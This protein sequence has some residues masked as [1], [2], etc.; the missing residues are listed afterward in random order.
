MVTDIEECME[1]LAENLS[2]NLP[3]GSF[4]SH[5]TDA[6]DETSSSSMRA[7]TD[8]WNVPQSV[9]DTAV[10]EMPVKLHLEDLCIT[11]D[12]TADQGQPSQ[13]SEAPSRQKK[14]LQREASPTKPSLGLQENK[15]TDLGLAEGST[16]SS[17]EACQTHVIARTLDW[18]EE[19]QSFQPP[20]DVL[21]LADVVSLQPLLSLKNILHTLLCH[22]LWIE[23]H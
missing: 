11:D 14:A 23:M 3:H 1:A 19:V 2:K 10:Q 4:T 17:H 21:L 20:F 5:F 15:A 6:R 7:T 13:S 9:I 12:R 22:C 18:T 8:G 16:A